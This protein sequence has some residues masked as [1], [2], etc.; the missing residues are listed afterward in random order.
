MLACRNETYEK[1]TAGSHEK[2]E[3]TTAYMQETETHPK[4]GKQT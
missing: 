1:T 2:Y 3:K 4:A